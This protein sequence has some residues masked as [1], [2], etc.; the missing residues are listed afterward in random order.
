M[1]D[2]WAT[3]TEKRCRKAKNADGSAK[4]NPSDPVNGIPHGDW[5]AKTNSAATADCHDA[6][7]R[8]SFHAFQAYTVKSDHCSVL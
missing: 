7:Q 1:N 5:C 2:G 3:D 6:Y 4:W 8:K